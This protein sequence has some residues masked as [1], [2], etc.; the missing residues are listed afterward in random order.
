[1][2]EVSV[3]LWVWLSAISGGI[4]IILFMV[5]RLFLMLDDVKATSMSSLNLLSFLSWECQKMKKSN[6]CDL[7]DETSILTGTRR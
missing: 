4:G 7:P 3:Y 2:S 5:I 6:G 1:M